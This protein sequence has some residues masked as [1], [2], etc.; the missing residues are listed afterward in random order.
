MSS[1]KSKLLTKK[2]I[3]NALRNEQ[4]RRL[5]DLMEKLQT[6]TLLSNTT[7]RLTLEEFYDLELPNHNLEALTLKFPAIFLQTIIDLLT[8]RLKEESLTFWLHNHHYASAFVIDKKWFKGNL[9]QLLKIDG[10]GVVFVSN[11]SKFAF[12][13]CEEDD[14]LVCQVTA[15]SR[16]AIA[17]LQWIAQNLDSH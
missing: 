2:L 5:P 8:D 13:Y 6:Q 14:P 1:Q 4:I 16:E 12:F 11:N 7:P 3:V 17:N 10:D 15:V 9:M